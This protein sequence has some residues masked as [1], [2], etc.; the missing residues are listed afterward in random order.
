MRGAPAPP[1][2]CACRALAHPAQTQRLHAC[3]WVWKSLLV[4]TAAAGRPGGMLWKQAARKEAK[5]KTHGEA[6]G[7]GAAAG[8]RP[9]LTPELIHARPFKG[10]LDQRGGGQPLEGGGDVGLVHKQP[11]KHDGHLGGGGV[12]GAAGS[13]A[14]PHRHESPPQEGQESCSHVYLPLPISWHL[15]QNKLHKHA[16][17]RRPHQD[18]GR[19]EG[20]RRLGG[21]CRSAHSQAQR[22]HNSGGGGGASISN[23]T[24]RRAGAGGGH[25]PPHCL[26]RGAK[27]GTLDPCHPALAHGTAGSGPGGPPAP[28]W[29]PA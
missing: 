2:R 10:L 26:G 21:G 16:P 28:T 9:V 29:P 4:T 17:P 25:C 3:V 20:Q 14:F 24:N 18:D 22:L 1:P 12:Q 5:P 6:A 19:A 15:G 8:C 7:C 13:A 23:P 11:A 27:R